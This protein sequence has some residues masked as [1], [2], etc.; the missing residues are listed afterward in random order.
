MNKKRISSIFMYIVVLAFLLT[1][2]PGPNA[3][4]IDSTAITTLVHSVTYTIDNTGKT[5]VGSP[6]ITDVYVDG[7][8]I[9]AATDGGGLS[10]ST[11]GG[12]SWTSY[13]TANGLGSNGVQGVYADGS[14]IYAATWNGLSVLNWL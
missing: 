12:T 5:T 13:T 14:D 2:C 6:S 4:I 10:V 8:E 9:Y 7:T 3:D 11:N 1:G